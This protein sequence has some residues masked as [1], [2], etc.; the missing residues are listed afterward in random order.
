MKLS[1]RGCNIHLV[2]DTN[3]IV[4]LNK[5]FGIVNYLWSIDFH[6]LL[7]LWLP[8][9]LRSSTSNCPLNAKDSRKR[10][11]SLF[12]ARVHLVCLSNE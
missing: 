10:S 2:V 5:Y 8:A 3:K 12:S 11:T 9:F 7:V 6:T 4:E 1:S